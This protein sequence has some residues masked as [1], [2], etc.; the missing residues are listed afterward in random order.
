MA[1]SG[2]SDTTSSRGRFPAARVRRDGEELRFLWGTLVFLRAISL[3][4][5]ASVVQ[6]VA[7]S[8]QTRTL[9]SRRASI[10]MPGGPGPDVG[11]AS[12]RHGWPTRGCRRMPLNGA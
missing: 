10:I 1:R 4:E 2:T 5:V 6:E 9:L 7:P 11:R 8:R 12:R 3:A